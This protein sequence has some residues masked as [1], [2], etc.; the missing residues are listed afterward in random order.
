M[1][2]VTL[3]EG[4]SGRFGLKGALKLIKDAGFDGYDASLF[5][6]MS[7]RGCFSGDDYKERAAEIRKYADDI[8]IPC[9]QAH[10]PC[11]NIRKYQDIVDCV[12]EQIRAIEISAI[13]GAPILVVHPSSI[14]DAEGNYEMIYSKL[15]P[16]ARELGVKIA[17]ENMF[18]WKDVEEG[19]TVPSA[20]GTAADFVRYI[21]YINDEYF[22]ACLDLG[23]ASM[24]NCE[25]APKMIR[26][27]GHD[28]LKAL[29][30]HDN[31][32][33]HDDHSFPFTGNMDW[34]EICKALSEI[35]Y[36]GDFT[37]EAN[38]FIKG[39]PDEL[40]PTCM[41]LLEQTGRYLISRI[42]EFK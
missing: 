26:A 14:T 37:F 13:L 20:C 28:R 10:S 27:L 40:V 3:T 21:D 19:D 35:N 18:A 4:L 16:L 9:L 29:H 8:G 17:T 11:P 23:H 41:E 1:K 7:R 32:C 22:T 15:L 5:Y 31:D 42:N 39:F 34:N 12:P 25:G 33:L 30:V 36:V 2:L 38:A 6:E 24:M